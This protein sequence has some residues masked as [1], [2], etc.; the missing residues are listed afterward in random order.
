MK[1]R[2]LTLAGLLGAVLVL[3]GCATNSTATSTSS[4]SATAT[5]TT[6]PSFMYVVYAHKGALKHKKGDHYV[7]M[8]DRSDLD[9]V[10]QFSDRPERIVNYITGKEMQNLWRP[11]YDNNF[12]TD[13]PNAVLNIQGHRPKIVELLR[14]KANGQQMIFTLSSDKTLQL[15]HL[16]GVAL[17]IDSSCSPWDPNGC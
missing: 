12:L 14:Q 13:P 2:S 8:L 15:G 17:T 9:Q 16:R 5:S 11:G 3:S 7:L 10:I 1:L 6:T 4:T